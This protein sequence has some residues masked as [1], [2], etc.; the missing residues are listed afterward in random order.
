MPPKKSGASQ[1]GTAAVNPLQKPA[2]PSTS[3]VPQSA[4]VTAGAPKAS[5]ALPSATPQKSLAGIAQPGRSRSGV[6][7]KAFKNSEKTEA[8]V[9]TKIEDKVFGIPALSQTP[10]N[11]IFIGFMRKVAPKIS[12]PETSY[13][14]LESFS[15]IDVTAEKLSSILKR[16][17][18]YENQFLTYIESVSK[19]EDMPSIEAAVVLLGMQNTRNLIL[20][21]QLNQV[22]TGSRIEWTKEGKLKTAPADVLKYS[23]KVEEALSGKKN[24]YADTAFAAAVLFDILYLTGL[25]L[26]EDKKRYQTFIDSMFYKGMISAF[27]AEEI[28]KTLPEF[29]FKKYLFGAALIHDC[30]RIVMA[31]LDKSYLDF[32]DR[33]EEKQIPA[34]LRPYVE[35]KKY[36]INHAVLGMFCCEYFKLF[37]VI[38]RAILFHHEPFM[39]RSKSKNLH[40]LAS[41]ICLSSNVAN[42][43]KKVDKKDDP[44]VA[45]WKGLELS[46]FPVDIK[47]VMKAT[48]MIPSSFS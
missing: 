32:L 48:T 37:S 2:A 41:V 9:L 30:G 34:S 1:S 15:N 46:H 4:P 45:G 12:I 21:M 16:N 7:P 5:P 19:R 36:G 31:M 47:N 14:F 13:N 42:H 38:E 27:M 20:G 18:Y 8:P 43:F 17:Q 11:P 33:C 39:L 24:Q 10:E 6:A 44:V 25:G 29:G 28:A 26:V 35:F 40:Q 23:L 3:V 22:L